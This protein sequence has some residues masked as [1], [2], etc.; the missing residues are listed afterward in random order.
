MRDAR[1]PSSS[2]F[3][4]QLHGA[5]V[6]IKS[7]EIGGDVRSLRLEIVSLVDVREKLGIGETGLLAMALL[8]G[9][10]MGEVAE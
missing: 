3:A 7:L 4:S 5:P 10:D 8:L 2:S 6:V 9:S 1:L